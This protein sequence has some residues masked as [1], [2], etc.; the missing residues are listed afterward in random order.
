MKLTEIVHQYKSGEITS[1]RDPDV[2]GSLANVKV[3]TLANGAQLVSKTDYKGIIDAEI[4][5]N[6]VA[7]AFGVRV[8]EMIR[9][10]SE[11]IL[12]E[13]I[14]DPVAA[15]YYD[16]DYEYYSHLTRHCNYKRIQLLD[17]VVG[18]ID[19][20]ENN[21]MADQH[22]GVTAID[23]GNALR[24][25]NLQVFISYEPSIIFSDEE[26][27]AID[28]GLSALIRKFDQL[29]MLIHYSMMMNRWETIKKGIKANRM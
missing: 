26:L 8:P 15:Y 5:T 11:T 24:L 16:N 2:R 21:F 1:Q 28:M 7:L 22:F 3:I 29:N 13:Y 12:M 25:S 27:Y 18:N 19:R 17:K 4:L 23:H 20:H 10:S 6:L 9:I 14:T